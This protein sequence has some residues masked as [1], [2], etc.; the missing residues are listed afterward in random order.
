MGEP[1]RIL[2]LDGGGS[3]ALIE[4]RALMDIY[5]DLSGHELLRQFDLVAANSGG[6]IV[7]GGL[8]AD[9]KL[10]KLLSLFEDEKLRSDIFSPTKKV[11]WPI[12][13]KLLGV[14][15]KYDAAH[16]LV[17]L[18]KA[19]GK[20]G[21][22][23]LPELVKGLGS[24]LHVV[25][26]SF[27]YDLTRAVFFRSEKVDGGARWGCGDASDATLAEAI[28]ASSDAPVNYFDAPAAFPD[29]P[30][31]YWDGGVAGTNNPILAAVTE[32]ICM[33]Q[34]SNEIAALSIGTGTMNLP[35]VSDELPD[36][37]WVQKRGS[38]TPIKDIAKLASSILDD[39]P[40]AATFIALAITRVGQED[41]P[42]RVIRMNP[43]VAPIPQG[44][45]WMNPPGLSAED[46]GAF[47]TLEM[48]AIKDEQVKLIEK[49]T[50]GWLKDQVLNQP[51][52]MD[53]VK[54]TAEIGQL[55]YSAAKAAWQK[56]APVRRTPPP[57]IDHAIP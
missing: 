54:W 34:T 23:T 40:D 2:S 50:D 28:H 39:P 51:I 15:P 19:L 25:I 41:L 31:R 24:P 43:M 27:D 17:A 38:S 10:S 14:G 3:W 30:N 1:F 44:A 5:G 37:A 55:Q 22:Q 21:D 47:K 45:T 8:L 57:K 4:V 11:F 18:R 48:D 6:S 12:L 16:K 13:R 53:R 33:N 7:L 20:A 49:L 9:W 52:R 35:M 42:D 36:A 32:A 29:K 26:T 56:L 46:F